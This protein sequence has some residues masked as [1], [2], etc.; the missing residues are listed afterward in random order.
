MNTPTLS[1]AD[2]ARIRTPNAVGLFELAAE[3]GWNDDEIAAAYN[4]QAG[5]GGDWTAA[6]VASHRAWLLSS[7]QLSQPAPA[8]GGDYLMLGGKRYNLTPA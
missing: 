4:S 1:A 6:N 2:A 3:R 5:T 7:H 8:A